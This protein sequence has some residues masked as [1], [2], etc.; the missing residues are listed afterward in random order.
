MTHAL[1][2]ALPLLLAAGVCLPASSNEIDPLALQVEPGTETKAGPAPLRIVLE[3]GAASVEARNGDR[4]SGH[5]A[6]FDLR[7]NTKLSEAW[8]FGF[9]NRLEDVDPAAPGRSSTTNSLR[10]LYLGWQASPEAAAIDFGRINHRQ[11]PAFGY[12]PTD[13]FRD[14]ALRTITTADPIALRETRLGTAM[15]R[16]TQL[17]AQS[18]A[19]I[20]IAPKLSDDGPNARAGSPDFGATNFEHRALLSGSTRFSDRFSAQGSLLLERGESAKLGF[21]AT[22]LLSD[23]LV[24]YGE[25]SSGKSTAL[26]D[27]ALGR[28]NPTKERVQQAAFGATWTLPGSLSLTLEAEYNGAGLDRR[29]GELLAAAGPVAQQRYFLLT[30]PNQELGSR[31]AWLLYVSQKG[32][33]LKQLD[34]TAFLRQNADDKSKFAWAELRYHWDRFDVA[35]QWQRSG[36]RDG[37]EF[38]LNPYRQ[39]VQ[40]LVSFY[41]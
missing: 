18:S 40:A 5:K 16:A 27:M 39:I 6:V 23:A 8:R 17:W 20:A 19:T 22:A 4:Q 3:A 30:Q 25:V 14:G 33:G 37:S 29:Q 36:G 9:S 38:G 35:L 21:S 32:L 1:Q 13:Y 2:R 11:G 34:F 15:V 10:E 31:R 24:A 28:P 26:L 12:N 41:L 7:Y